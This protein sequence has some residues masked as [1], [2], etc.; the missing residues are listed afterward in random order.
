MPTHGVL[1]FLINTRNALN[2]DN[3]Y[4]YYTHIV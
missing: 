2:Y 4:I 3:Y 1:I